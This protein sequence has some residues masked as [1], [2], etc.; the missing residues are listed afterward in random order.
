MCVY[1]FED[2]LSVFKLHEGGGEE[3][4]DGERKTERKGHSVGSDQRGYFVLGE[5][6]V[7]CFCDRGNVNWLCGCVTSQGGRRRTKWTQNTPW[8]G[9]QFL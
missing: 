7:Y 1:L 3:R 6:A 8:E 4:R 2:G 5:T 9:S